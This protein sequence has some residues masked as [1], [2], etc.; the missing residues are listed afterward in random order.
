MREDGAHH[1]AAHAWRRRGQSVPEI[2]RGDSMVAR[3]RAGLQA[4]TGR[5]GEAPTDAEGP[6]QNSVTRFCGGEQ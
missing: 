4:A 1:A 2:N 5:M 3:C 6:Q